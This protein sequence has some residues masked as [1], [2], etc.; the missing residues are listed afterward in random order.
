MRFYQIAAIIF[1]GPIFLFSW[2]VFAGDGCDDLGSN[3]RWAELYEKLLQARSDSDNE[4]ALRYGEEMTA[5]CDRSPILNF[6]IADTHKRAGD[7][8]KA[9]EYYRKTTLE[10]SGFVV[11]SQL[12]S[13]FWDAR[14]QAERQVR[15]RNG[16][17]KIHEEI[18]ADRQKRESE[19][20]GSFERAAEES[21][22]MREA[23]ESSRRFQGKS[24]SI[25]GG[26]LTGFG[27][28]GVVAGAVLWALGQDKIDKAGASQFDS[29]KL[30]KSIAGDILKRDIG[31][32]MTAGGSVMLAVGIPLWVIGGGILSDL[33]TD[34]VKAE[35]SGS[36][37][38]LR[39]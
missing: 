16:R 38:Q 3:E 10:T 28:A 19:V 13:T 39:F 27:V 7:L 20:Q 11:D 34:T 24:L 12:H 14:R 17:V 33:P 2:T 22:L 9:L 6:V 23:Y 1:F 35:F 5:I 21:N 4:G 25:A 36:G 31:I 30:K 29:G 37:F 15:E 8:D 32:G 26:S 18:E